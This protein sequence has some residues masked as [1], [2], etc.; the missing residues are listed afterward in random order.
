M[1]A[2]VPI[3]KRKRVSP[4]VVGLAAWILP[5][6]GH[7]LVGERARGLILCVTLL[8]TYWTG[9]CVGGP[10]YTTDATENRLWFVAEL[11][12]GPQV[13]ALFMA[14][15]DRPRTPEE[16]PVWPDSEIALIYAAVAGLLNL[17]VI[18]DAVGRA[19]GAGVVT[20]TERPGSSPPG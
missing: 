8:L 20:A 7:F 16:M 18:F 9:V 17:L 3:R 5:G 19:A 12:M 2:R 4:V 13:V 15:K 6:F 11:G 10:T 14:S 1:A